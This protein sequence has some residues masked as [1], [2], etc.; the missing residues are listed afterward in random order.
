MKLKSKNTLVLVTSC[1][2]LLAASPA[3]A[4]GWLAPPDHPFMVRSS[5]LGIGTSSSSNKLDL[6]T[7]S[8]P[9]VAVDIS[10]FVNPHWAVQVLA[11]YT[12]LEVST[13]S[14]A[15]ANAVNNG[16]RSLGSV[17]LLP[18]IVT[19]QYHFNPL[20]R[21]QPYAGVGFNVNIFPNVT[22]TLKALKTHVSTSVGAVGELGADYDLLGPVFLNATFKYLYTQPSVT[23]LGGAIK[24]D[25]NVRGFIGSAA[26][27]YRF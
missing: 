17:D 4:A 26:I 10:Y 18:P 24:D 20:G 9:A 13:R 6:T 23:V 25:L 22:G 12:S 3:S 15:I 21:L 2:T 1:A 14:Q 8:T 27:G 16:N 7:N 11:T 5:L 19:L